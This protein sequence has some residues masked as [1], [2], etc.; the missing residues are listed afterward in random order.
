MD[1][2]FLI[3]I[4]DHILINFDYMVNSDHHYHYLYQQNAIDFVNGVIDLNDNCCWESMYS[5]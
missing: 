4:I 5:F 3:K 1:L 2:Y